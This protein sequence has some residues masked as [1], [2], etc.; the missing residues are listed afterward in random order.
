M[1]RRFLLISLLAIFI[2]NCVGLH[3]VVRY[4]DMGLPGQEKR[5]ENHDLRVLVGRLR[6]E[7]APVWKW[8]ASDWP[9]Y[10]GFYRPIP[11]I[12]VI[13]DDVLFGDELN[14]YKIQNWIIGLLCSLLLFW[15]VWE[16]FR[17]AALAAG[18]SLV[19]SYWQSGIDNLISGAIHVRGAVY[20]LAFG[21]AVFVAIYGLAFGKGARLKW[22]LVA[23]AI[24]YLG[25]EYALALQWTDVTQQPFD[26]RSIGWPVG[27]TATLMTMF[28][29]M[30]LASYCRFERTRSNL[31]AVLALIALILAFCSY[32][33]A[34]VVPALLLGCAIALSLQTVRVRWLWHVVP[35]ATL[36]L[37][38]WLH[39]THIEPDSR[40]RKQ[41]ARGQSGGL[42]DTL[43]WLFQSNRDLRFLKQIFEP[44]IGLAVFAM[45]LYW[46]ALFDL[47][48]NVCGLTIATRRWL[49]A[50]FGLIAAVGSYAPMAFQHPLSHYFHL[51]LA[52]RSIFVV[53][54][55]FGCIEM[56]RELSK[57]RTKVPATAG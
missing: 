22:L 17:D 10:N 1:P 37:Y 23:G 24:G 43:T 18:S 42:R 36:G 30:S 57:E 2:V 19:F 33:Q 29:L 39:L 11:T 4:D 32:E 9:L 15:L 46:K 26:Y 51:P 16:L 31:F 21:T 27:R 52:M 35:W 14:K 50:F 34:V 13:A 25:R 44:S 53:A 5:D 7:G 47:V 6:D 48:A 40:Y 41:A 38:L 45:E 56:L 54:L 55:T 20:W 49:P 28:A 8:F 12:S 3:H